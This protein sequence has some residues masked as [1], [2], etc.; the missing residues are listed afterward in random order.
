MSREYSETREIEMPK[1]SFFLADC[2]S[3]DST[4]STSPVDWDQLWTV[5]FNINIA[6]P[7]RANDHLNLS[8][9]GAVSHKYYF[10][11]PETPSPDEGWVAIYQSQY[12]M[13][14]QPWYKH[15]IPLTHIEA[16]SFIDIN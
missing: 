16:T 3:E 4:I 15:A 5:N 7:G 13:L 9:S 11:P 1:A 8:A 6:T 10:R 2:G 12:Q 14:L